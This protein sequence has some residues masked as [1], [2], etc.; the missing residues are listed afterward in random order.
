MFT[1]VKNYFYIYM[2]TINNWSNQLSLANP[3]YRLIQ[4]MIQS[5]L[6]PHKSFKH[7]I[8]NHYDQKQFKRM[9]NLLCFIQILLIIRFIASIILP[10]ELAI[11][12]V[13]P[14]FSSDA[15]YRAFS[16]ALTEKL[17]APIICLYD[18]HEKFRENFLKAKQR[19]QQHLTTN[20]PL[21]VKKF[22][23]NNDKQQKSY[24]RLCFFINLMMTLLKFSMILSTFIW[25][26]ITIVDFI[27]SNQIDNNN[28]YTLITIIIW[29]IW[30]LITIITGSIIYIFGTIATQ[31]FI[32]T[33]IR[34]NLQ[35]KKID[36]KFQSQR[37]IYNYKNN[38]HI[39][40]INNSFIIFR[41]L[42][43][44]NQQILSTSKQTIIIVESFYSL[45]T[46]ML[47][48]LFFQL[49]YLYIFVFIFIN[50]RLNQS[51]FNRKKF[52]HYS[53]FQF[54]WIELS[55]QLEDNQIGFDCGHKFIFTFK[56]IFKFIIYFL[57]NAFIFINLFRNYIFS[58]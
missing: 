35:Y 50:S 5:K 55:Y 46:I 22:N 47:Y 39:K 42:V 49:K 54:H 9:F 58:E 56:I 31:F 25:I 30:E 48:S 44:I 23:H 41:Q 40:C 43:K 26:I 8:D 15:N 32:V 7:F 14:L 18:E 37:M 19:Q 57:F 11:K 2:K 1:I 17:F 33:V 27:I 34:W 13:Q 24:L 3:S 51:R 21:F 16:L 20:N 29:F 10:Y 36:E 45:F 28:G 52:L 53:I 4:L 12:I 6:I 38:N